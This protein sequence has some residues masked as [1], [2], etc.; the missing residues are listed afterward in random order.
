MRRLLK[1]KKPPKPQWLIFNCKD[2]EI[3]AGPGIADQIGGVFA[4]SGDIHLIGYQGFA[5]EG[6]GDY[7]TDDKSR[8]LPDYGEVGRIGNIE[9]IGAGGCLFVS[10][11][12]FKTYVA[13][14]RIMAVKHYIEIRAA[15]RHIGYPVAADIRAYIATAGA[16][17]LN[18]I[19]AALGRIYQN[20]CVSFVGREWKCLLYQHGAQTGGTPYGY[21]VETIRNGTVAGDCTKTDIRCICCTINSNI[22]GKIVGRSI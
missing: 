18:Q 3:T 11:D 12:I 17:H 22:D 13:E 4:S 5:G 9:L 14:Y 1:F 6:A 2:T 20:H 16:W 15:V 19:D 21:G 7:S 10:S 8:K